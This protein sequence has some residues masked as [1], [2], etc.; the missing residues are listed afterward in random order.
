MLV[1]LDRLK[2]KNN[3]LYDTGGKQIWTAKDTSGSAIAIDDL[4]N[5]VV[6]GYE[7]TVKYD[8][9]GNEIWVARYSGLEKNDD[10]YPTGLTLDSL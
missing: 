7:A 8:K 5:V 10:N 1:L 9:D 3:S 4:G 6:T 2:F